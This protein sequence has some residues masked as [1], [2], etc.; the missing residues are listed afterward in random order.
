MDESK[1]ADKLVGFGATKQELEGKKTESDSNSG[2]W[3]AQQPWEHM[4]LDL[5]MGRVF[6][7]SGEYYIREGWT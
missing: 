5:G 2:E 1:G 6:G 3:V 7:K 4:V